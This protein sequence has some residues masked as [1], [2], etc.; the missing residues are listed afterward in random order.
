MAD[1][2]VTFGRPNQPLTVVDHDGIKVH[3]ANQLNWNFASLDNK[4]SAAEIEFD[5][6]NDLFFPSRGGAHSNRCRTP[7]SDGSGSVHGTVPRPAAPGVRVKKYTIK[8]Y[9]SAGTEIMSY[10]LD[11]E[12]V[13]V[14]P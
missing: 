7:L 4:I 1:I 8:A 9:D 12:V 10:H 5:D 6:P 3:T 2:D 11:P 14:D 13:T